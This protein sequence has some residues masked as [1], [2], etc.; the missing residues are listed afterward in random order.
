M[1][2]AEHRGD[3]RGRARRARRRTDRGDRRQLRRG[4]P[5]RPAGER[6]RGRVHHRAGCA[7]EHG[8]GEGRLHRLPRRGRGG[9]RRA[10]GAAHGALDH[11]GARRALCGD[12]ARPRKGR[13]SQRDPP[14][15]RPADGRGVGDDAKPRRHR[16]RAGGAHRRVRPS[17][18]RCA[19][20]PRALG[21]GGYPDGLAGKKIPL[22]ARII[23][24]CDTYDAIITDRPYRPARS[25]REACEELRR[26]ADTQLDPSV[27]DAVLSELGCD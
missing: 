21:R 16:R 7:D 4:R 13:H 10:G 11:A 25:T 3:R 23:A 19:R 20:Q 27:V 14:E 18:S 8:R 12:A 5:P 2:R 9:A 6:P 15:A 26:V 24:A 22:A 17:R 1:G